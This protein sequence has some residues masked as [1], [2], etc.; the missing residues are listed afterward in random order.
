MPLGRTK[1][2]LLCG[3]VPCP[4][5]ARRPVSMPLTMRAVV[6]GGRRHPVPGH[7]KV[8]HAAAR[9]FHG[10][11]RFGVEAARLTNVGHSL[12]MSDSSA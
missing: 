9:S 1:R 11:D 5:T 4:V 3:A 6:V 12:E 7:Q 8:C 10:G 2:V